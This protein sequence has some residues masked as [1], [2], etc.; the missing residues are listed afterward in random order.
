MLHT[1][2]NDF[3]N[4]SKFLLFLME[5]RLVCVMIKKIIL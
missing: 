4:K 5:T 2:S 3:L 1:L